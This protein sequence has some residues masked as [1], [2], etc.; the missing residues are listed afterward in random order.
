MGGGLVQP[1]C[2]RRGTATPLPRGLVSHKVLS[3]LPGTPLTGHAVV[4][5][6]LGGLSG[7]PRGGDDDFGLG[8]HAPAPFFSLNRSAV[9]ENW[10][11]LSI[12]G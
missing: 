12:I 5:E 6:G 8:P 9:A 1:L 4:A 7:G 2:F 10:K 3:G 11:K